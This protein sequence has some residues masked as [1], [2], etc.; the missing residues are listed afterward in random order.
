[1]LKSFKNITVFSIILL[2]A[3]SIAIYAENQSSD[4]ISNLEKSIQ[5]QQQAVEQMLGEDQGTQQQATPP[6]QTQPAPKKTSPSITAITGLVLKEKDV[7]FKQKS[8]ANRVILIKTDDD[9]RL[10]VDLGPTQNLKD[11]ASLLGKNIQ[12][13]GRLVRIGNRMVLMA[14]QLTVNGKTTQILR[15]IHPITPKDTGTDYFDLPHTLRGHFINEKTITVQNTGN[16]D[17]II[18]LKTDDDQLF[19]TDLGPSDAAAE[20]QFKLNQPVEVSGSWVR[21]GD[22]PV[23][24][25]REVTVNGQTSQIKHPIGQIWKNADENLTGAIIRMKYVKVQGT[26]ISHKVVMIAT[27]NNGQVIGDLGPKKITEAAPIDLGKTI[28]VQG[29]L[30]GIGDRLVLLAKTL[31]VDGKTYDIQKSIL[32]SK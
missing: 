1:M 14:N 27:E 8:G 18:L 13:E 31:T 15:L 28:N 17:K 2:L 12:A 5:Q 26:D 32:P 9:K 29:W 6:T 7:T 21:V 10:A 24:L 3:G 20:I 23:L 30:V 25:A 22:H 11:F 19:V 16:Q 4:E